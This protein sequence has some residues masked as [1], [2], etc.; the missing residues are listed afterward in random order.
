MVTLSGR[1]VI[2]WVLSLIVSRVMFSTLTVC[3]RTPLAPTAICMV[4]CFTRSRTQ[5]PPKT[6]RRARCTGGRNGPLVASGNLA[7]TATSASGA[8]GQTSVSVV[9]IPIVIPEV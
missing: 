4:S 9:L 7:S 6:S 5:S 8:F 1:T 2:A 3:G